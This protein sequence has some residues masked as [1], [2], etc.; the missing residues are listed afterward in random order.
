MR[1]TFSYR[2]IDAIERAAENSLILGWAELN[3]VIQR[4]QQPSADRLLGMTSSKWLKAGVADFQPLTH[5]VI[6]IPRK[7]IPADSLSDKNRRKRGRANRAQEKPVILR[8]PKRLKDPLPPAANL[9]PGENHTARSNFHAV[10]PAA[11]PSKHSV[12]SATGAPARRAEGPT[13]SQPRAKR[14]TSVALGINSKSDSALKGRNT[15]SPL[16]AVC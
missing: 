10:I 7:A 2:W 13:T 6:G 4:N 1:A 9:S 14:G 12:T 8:E 5:R 15:A 16:T 11:E 3:S